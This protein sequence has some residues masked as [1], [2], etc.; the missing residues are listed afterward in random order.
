MDLEL[1]FKRSTAGHQ[2][3]PTAVWTLQSA[4]HC[5]P[6]AAAVAAQQLPDADALPPRA[7]NRSREVESSARTQ[8]ASREAVKVSYAGC[9]G[10]FLWA[11]V[12]LVDSCVFS[13][14]KH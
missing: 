6:S 10:F 11:I 14:I 12:L 3:Q 7:W 5:W 9:L 4:M 1:A 13:P 8:H 2:R